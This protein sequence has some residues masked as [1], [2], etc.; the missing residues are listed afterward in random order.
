MLRIILFMTGVF[1]LL[2]AFKLLTKALEKIISPYLLGGLKKLTSIKYIAIV[3]GI[4]LTMFLQSSSIVLICLLGLVKTRYINVLQALW[5]LL[6]AN[7]GTTITNHLLILDLSLCIPA[8]MLIGFFLFFIKETSYFYIGVLCQSIAILFIAMDIMSY[9]L[10]GMQNNILFIELF[11]SLENPLVGLIF[12]IITTAIL[13]SSSASLA[14][15]Q[16]FVLTNTLPL[17]WLIWVVFGQNIGTCFTGVLA[18]VGANKKTRQVILL[19]FLINILGMLCFIPCLWIFD[20]LLFIEISNPNNLSVQ[21]AN[22]NTI[23]NIITV[24]LLLPFDKILVYLSEQ[25]LAN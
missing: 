13:Q 6:G 11:S 15:L 2:I 24:F 14:V 23:Y 9:S 7:I 17:S 20:I 19:P 10:V 25:M 22:F 4:V 1:L 18:I 8:L 21:L 12:G 3:Y 16:S 5:I